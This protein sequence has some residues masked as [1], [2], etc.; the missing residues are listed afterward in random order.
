MVMVLG[1]EI[2]TSFGA[3]RHR[4]FDIRLIMQAFELC[5]VW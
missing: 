4:A 1:A 3:R 5:P 2:G